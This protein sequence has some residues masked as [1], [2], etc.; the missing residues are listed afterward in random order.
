MPV[1]ICYRGD[2]D[3]LAFQE[4]GR[5][6]FAATDALGR[7]WLCVDAAARGMRGDGLPDPVFDVMKAQHALHLRGESAAGTSMSQ[8][9][10]PDRAAARWRL[11]RGSYP[12][13]ERSRARMAGVPI[14]ASQLGFATRRQYTLSIAT[15]SG[16]HAFSGDSEDEVWH[17]AAERL[18]G[19][20]LGNEE[21]TMP[22]LSFAPADVP[23]YRDADGVIRVGDT[24]IVLDA[25]LDLHLGGES[26]EAIAAA[27][28]RVPL[29]DVYAVLAFYHRN[30]AAVDDY[31]N[32]REAEAER[33][34]LEIEAAQS[35][36][37][38]E[39]SAE[40]RGRWAQRGRVHAASGR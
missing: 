5:D 19:P 16:F 14:S 24:R 34:R 30:K 31:L 37:P 18:G 29:A 1:F 17:R 32:A 22:T 38:A 27:Y 9:S 13:E 23:L 4:D 21:A 15:P 39:F 36:T 25:L 6:V 26:A 3:N 11:V 7:R 40:A 33:L 20:T 12:P 8:F 28:P 10:A 2:C 35:P